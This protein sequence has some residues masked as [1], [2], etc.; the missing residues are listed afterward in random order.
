MKLIYC[1]HF[2]LKNILFENILRI[3]DLSIFTN[4]GHPNSSYVEFN[5][6]VGQKN[7]HICIHKQAEAY[8]MEIK[9]L[10]R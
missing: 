6:T 7:T 9:A 10:L 1:L 2:I 4:L 3:I 5:L 8:K